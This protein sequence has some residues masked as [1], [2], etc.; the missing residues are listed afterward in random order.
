MSNSTDSPAGAPEFAGPDDAGHF[1]PYGGRFV[2][3]TLMAA[4]DAM[5]A[6]Y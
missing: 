3:E 6:A 2:A 1:G 5:R 4:L